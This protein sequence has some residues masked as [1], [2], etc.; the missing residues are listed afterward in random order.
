MLT[1]SSASTSLLEMAESWNNLA[2]FASELPD[3]DEELAYQQPNAFT[4]FPK[5]PDEIRVKIW[6]LTFPANTHVMFASPHG[7]WV[8]NF[9]YLIQ[10]PK[11]PRSPISLRVNFESR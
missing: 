7:E 11:V 2:T 3:P 1:Y 6:R 9:N 4:L 5:L 10:L 8:H